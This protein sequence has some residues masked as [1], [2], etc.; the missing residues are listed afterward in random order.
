MISGLL[1]QKFK[2]GTGLA[3]LALTCSPAAQAQDLSSAIGEALRTNPEIGE[4]AANRRAIDFEYQQARQIGNPHVI[5]EG[6][7]GPSWIDSRTSRLFGNDEDILFARQASVTMQ[8]NLYSFGRNDAEKDRQASRVDSASHRVFERSEFV[9]LDVSQAYFDVARLREVINYADLNVAFHQ[10]MADDISRGVSSGLIRETDSLQAQERLATSKISLNEIEENHEIAMAKFAQLVGHGIGDAR[11]PPRFEQLVPQTLEGALATA[12]ANNPTIKIAYADL[13]VARANYRAAKAETKPELSFEVSGRTGEHTDSFRDHNSDL[14]AQLVL[15]YEFR[16]GIKNSAVQEHLNWVDEQRQ[17]V[18]TIE[19]NVDN[20]VRNA[21]ITRERM[22]MRVRDL[23]QRVATG[24]KLRADYQRERVLGN[25]SLLDILNAQEDLFQ[26]QSSLV[27]AKYAEHYANYRL[28]ASTGQLLEA[29]GLEPR[30]EAIAK[31][32]GYQDVPLTPMAETEKRKQPNHHFDTTYMD[33]DDSGIR[34]ISEWR[35]ERQAEITEEV[36]ELSKVVTPVY[37]EAKPTIA[38]QISHEAQTETV[39]KPVK[40]VVVSNN[41]VSQS[42]EL[43]DPMAIVEHGRIEP[44]QSVTITH[45]EPIQISLAEVPSARIE[46]PK[47]N[48][49]STSEGSP[50][51]HLNATEFEVMSQRSDVNYIESMGVISKENIVYMKSE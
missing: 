8:K 6:R 24:T 38:G 48:F 18:M 13:D 7:A 50:I 27:T 35:K 34:L 25:R 46:Q 40:P 26:A 43:Y 17:R 22:Q 36:L 45:K 15:R 33:W 32:R 49:L 39:Y 30:N 16:G 41:A 28:L 31:T 20:L 5:V 11:T 3:V 37:E 9:G 51:V 4:A 12:R 44:V 21:W 2:L 19:R 42:T 10:Q 29:F 47:A 23:E 14:R 1:R